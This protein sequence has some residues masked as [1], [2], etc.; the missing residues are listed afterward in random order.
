MSKSKPEE[1]A[2]GSTDREIAKR[3]STS[4]LLEKFTDGTWRARQN[5][6]DVEGTGA[7]AA[8]ATEDLA[9]KVAELRE[10]GEL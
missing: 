9:G 2:D 10:S 8:R 1:T 4:V 7:S 3:D 5:G 6:L